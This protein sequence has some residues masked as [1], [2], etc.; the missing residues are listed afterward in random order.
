MRQASD[1]SQMIVDGTR[2]DADQ[3][4]E[5]LSRWYVPVDVVPLAGVPRLRL[6]AACGALPGIRF[7]RSEIVDGLRILP[8]VAFDAVGFVLPTSGR[9]EVS[10]TREPA[11]A[12]PNEA[13]A[14]DGTGC[15]AL[16]YS[17][18]FRTRSIAIDRGVLARRLAALIDR[19]I[20][21]EIEFAPRIGAQA[22]RYGALSTLLACVT[23]ETFGKSLGHS[24]FTAA[25]MP[26]VLIDF[27][28]ETWPHTYSR[29]FEREPPLIAPRYVKA[30]VDFI[31]AHPQA[32]APATDIAGFAGVSLRALQYGF[33]RFVGLSITE[34]QRR[35][36]LQRARAELL[37]SADSIEAVA[38]RWGFSNAGR[39]S[40][41]FKAAFGLFPSELTRD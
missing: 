9:L 10:G 24:P 32:P 39:F 6:R 30:A 33:R 4:A 28:L 20:S 26:A 2:Q 41:H 38:R 11:S 23:D 25:R 19:P 29:E 1:F 34:Y 27:I 35:V 13:L 16:C 7:S 3:I 12:G 37:T 21:R 40:H 18:D 36:R 15:Q 14:V 31:E 22:I 8:R 5:S 17:P